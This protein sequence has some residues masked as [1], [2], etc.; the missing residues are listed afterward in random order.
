V[1]GGLAIIR[2]NAEHYGSKH[3]TYTITIEN[4][5]ISTKLI[6]STHDTPAKDAFQNLT[7]LQL[8]KAAGK[9]L[10]NCDTGLVSGVSI[11]W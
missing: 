2:F 9:V 10:S 6:K 7:L 1:L 8:I 4:I 3:L 5:D 11:S